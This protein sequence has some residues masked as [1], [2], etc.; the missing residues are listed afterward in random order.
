MEAAVRD[1][2]SLMKLLS[3]PAATRQLMADLDTR[4]EK[5]RKAQA[6]ADAAREKLTAKEIELNRRRQDLDK[7][8]GI[9]NSREDELTRSYRAHEADKDFHAS[10]VARHEEAV[11]GWQASK[12]G[13]DERLSQVTAREN[14]VIRDEVALRAR[15]EALE[16]AKA[17]LERRIA[18][19]TAP[20]QVA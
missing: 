8:E 15:M 16:K 11:A 1:L 20:V 2:A 13:I 3:D 17:E 18:L 9:L 14:A 6:D 10:N 19:I 4:I 5:H 7:R 12:A